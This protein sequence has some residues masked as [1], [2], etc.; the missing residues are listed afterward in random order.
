M[1]TGVVQVQVHL[2]GI[3]VRELPQFQSTMM[4]DRSRR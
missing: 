2:A 1:L 4:S 3:G